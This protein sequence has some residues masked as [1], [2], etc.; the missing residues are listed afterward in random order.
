MGCVTSKP[1]CVRVT[2]APGSVPPVGGVEHLLRGRGVLA[3]LR[4]IGVDGGGDVFFDLE[5]YADV[6]RLLRATLRADAPCQ[7]LNHAPRRV[8]V[9]EVVPRADAGL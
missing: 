4:A 5:H 8:V 1:L 6:E 7:A 9:R 3:E 2:C